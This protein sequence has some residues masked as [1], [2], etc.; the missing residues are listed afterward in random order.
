[1]G[2]DPVVLSCSCLMVETHRSM[3]KVSGAPLSE[4]ALM[5]VTCEPLQVAAGLG[6][7]LLD[8]AVM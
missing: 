7:R 2:R 6:R 4:T 8:L 5:T 3:A 1:M